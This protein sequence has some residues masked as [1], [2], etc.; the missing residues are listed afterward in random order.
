MKEIEL[1]LEFAE[2]K[3]KIVLS[4]WEVIVQGEKGKKRMEWKVLNKDVFRKAVMIMFI[5]ERR[6]MYITI[7]KR[8]MIMT[9]DDDRRW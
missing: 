7:L 2:V 3:I 8:V 1:I 4:V 5:S 6:K 9:S